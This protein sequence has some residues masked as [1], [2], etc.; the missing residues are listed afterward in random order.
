MSGWSKFIAQLM[1]MV[2][3]VPVNKDEVFER[4]IATSFSALQTRGDR[5]SVD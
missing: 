3:G 4:K 1:V 2:F 5:A